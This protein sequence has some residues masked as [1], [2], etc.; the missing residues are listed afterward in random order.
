MIFQTL[1]NI[2]EPLR[3]LAQK[4]L[5]PAKLLLCRPAQSAPC[6]SACLL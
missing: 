5:R 6:L 2:P 4:E 1:T 3:S